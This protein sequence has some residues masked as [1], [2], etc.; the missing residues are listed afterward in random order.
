MDG[1]LRPMTTRGF[2]GTAWGHVHR[3]LFA[4]LL[5]GMVP[6]CDRS[7][8]EAMT[9]LDLEG[10]TLPSLA[11]SVTGEAAAALS[12]D[13]LFELAGPRVGNLPEISEAE[14]RR[15][16]LAWAR[17][18]GPFNKGRMEKGHGAPIDFSSLCL[19]ARLL[20][21]NAVRLP[22]AGDTFRAAQV[23][24]FYVDGATLRGERL[25]SDRACGLCAQYR[26]TG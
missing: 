12:P 18:F 2:I 20:R 22:L 23:L 3:T 5:I 17:T 4:S 26:C 7:S 6:A 16:A 13:G 8:S 9:G 14:A 10:M 11:L 1:N 25:A 24:G 19:P 15:Q 21:G